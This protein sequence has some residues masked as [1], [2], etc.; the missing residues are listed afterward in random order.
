MAAP[1]EMGYF[2][3][4]GNGNWI[5]KG[6]AGNVDAAVSFY[7]IAKV[8]FSLRMSNLKANVSTCFQVEILVHKS[9]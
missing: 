8:I 6:N 7:F 9:R 1:G 2:S 4:N 3:C 5:K